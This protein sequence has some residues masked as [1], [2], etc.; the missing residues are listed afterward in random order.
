[1]KEKSN[2][3]MQPIREV[4]KDIPVKNIDVQLDEN[5]NDDVSSCEICHGAHFVYPMKENGKPDYSKFVP[6]ICVEE[7]LKRERYV[8][9]MR[10]CEL[11]PRTEKMTFENFEKRQGLEE[12]YKEARY[13]AEGDTEYPW[14]TLM[15]DTDT[16]KTHLGIAAV[17]RWLSRGIPARYA[18]V[19]L[20]LDELRRGFR[21]DGD[22]SYESRF[23]FYLNVPLLMLDDLGTENR[24]PW[25]HEKLDVII[26]YRLMNN[27]ALIVTTN[28]T[29]DDL[30][31]RI[32]SRLKRGGNVVGIDAP[33]YGDV[34]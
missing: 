6:C 8:R 16:G 24:T 31:F 10:K 1:V 2:N 21:E 5:L 18:H 33:G 3:E 28:S 27:L 32:S 11:P 22:R 17:R 12:A 34:E 20:L 30:P 15:G 19:P 7:K 23:D 9:L 26:D 29:L 4:L 13:L 14:L 25:V